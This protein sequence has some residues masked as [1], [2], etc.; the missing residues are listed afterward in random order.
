MEL[1]PIFQK[2]DGEHKQATSTSKAMKSKG[3][4]EEK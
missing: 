4:T 3:K 1:N 2:I